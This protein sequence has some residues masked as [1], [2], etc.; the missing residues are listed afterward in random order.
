MHTSLLIYLR[1]YFILLLSI[2]ILV[3]CKGTEGPQGPQGTAGAKGEAGVAGPQGP[4]GNANVRQ[5]NFGSKSHTGTDLLLTFPGTF[6]ADVI[7][8]SLIYVY[9]KQ[10][11]TSTS[12]QA[13]AYWFS[14]PGETVTGNEYSFYTAAGSTAAPGVFIR[15]V[16]NYLPGNEAFDAI[17]VVVIEASSNVNGRVIHEVDY[18]DYESVRKYYNLPL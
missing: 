7:E 16:V 4:V 5:I 6:T 9:V 12:G 2:Q 1:R 18:R 3:S 17:R 10:N 13:A 15:R 11:G 8:K 14:V